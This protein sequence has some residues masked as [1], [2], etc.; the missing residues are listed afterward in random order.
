M[1]KDIT[2]FTCGEK[3]HRSTECKKSK[4]NGSVNG[5]SGVRAITCFNCGKQGHRS[6][7]CPNKRVGGP[8]KKEGTGGKVA[9]LVVEGEK[10]NVAWGLV[11]GV[12][13]KVVLIDSGAKLGG[14]TCSRLA[15]ID[16]REGDGVISIVPMNLTDKEEYQAFT[17]AIE[18]Y[19]NNRVVEYEKPAEVNVLTRSQA[20]QEEV[21]DKCEDD[22]G[23]EDLWCTVEEPDQK[24]QGAEKE[25]SAVLGEAESKQECLRESVVEGIEELEGEPKELEQITVE[26]SERE[27]SEIA[28][29]IGPMKE[30]T[31]GKDFREKLL[32]DDSLKTWRELGTRGERGFKWKNELL[33]RGMY[34]SWEEFGDVIVVPREYRGRILEMSHERSGHLGG[35]KVAKMVGRYFLWPGMVK[36]I[37]EHC[38]S[39]DTC[40]RKSKHKP[41]KV[42]AVDRPVL[43]EPFESVAVDLVGPLP[44]G[45]GGCRFLL[46]YVCMAT[47]WPEAVPL[48]SITAKAV[49]EGL[50]NVFARTAIP[51]V[52]LSDQGTQFCGRVVRQIEK[53]RTSPYHPQTN[54][55][56]ERM[57]ATLKSVLGR[58]IDDGV[59]WV[60]QVPLALYVLRQMPHAD[61]GFSP[62][63]MVFG[64]RVRTPLALGRPVPWDI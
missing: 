5:G 56:V 61:S 44:K 42:P 41:R 2:C 29:Q 14:L 33:L 57:H 23:V 6:V 38:R 53:L 31:D 54:G 50:W 1:N 4:W 28:G 46:T 27:F 36:E 52:M 49:A 39:C 19:R 47:R 20:R 16:E 55:M 34:V 51:E 8:V 10:D 3:G 22:A 7:D 45:K 26:D 30:G 58:C 9:K 40:Q 24:E 17:T 59:D 35:E 60:G 11:N 32:T 37:E 25:S 43:T 21:L 63:D 18:E 12:K 64:F 15:M 48:R 62:F 13:S